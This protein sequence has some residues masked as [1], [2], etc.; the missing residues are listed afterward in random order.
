MT[1]VEAMLELLV[2]VVVVVAMMHVRHTLL[3]KEKITSARCNF[4]TSMLHP[5]TMVEQKNISTDPTRGG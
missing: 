1:F 5:Q 3:L 2:V 4:T